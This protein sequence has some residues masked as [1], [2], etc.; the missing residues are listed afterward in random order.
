MINRGSL[1]AIGPSLDGLEVLGNRNTIT[2]NGSVRTSGHSASALHALGNSNI[3]LNTGTLNT[4]TGGAAIG[5]FAEGAGN[6]A[7]NQGTIVTGGGGAEGLSAY[8]DRNVLTNAGAIATFGPVGNGIRV[9]GNNNSILNTG[10][11]TTSG[12][13]GRGIKVDAGTGN[14][15]VNR[16]TI[17]TSGNRAYGI[18]VASRAGETTTIINE[19]SGIIR[20]RNDKF[21]KFDA[22]NE[23]VRNFG[24]LSAPGGGAAAD[25][26][27]GSDSFLIGA[28]SRITGFVDASDGTDTF[29][30]GGSANASFDAALIGAGAQY[31]NFE[32]YEKLGPSTWVVTGSNDGVMPWHV[33]QGSLLVTGV[34]GGADMNVYGGATLGGSGTV[35]SINARAGSTLTPGMNGIASLAVTGNVL[36]A[37]G[38]VYKIDLDAS[39]RS[40]RIVAEGS[41]DV[42][43]GTVQVNTL[44]GDYR[45]GSRW[46][47]LTARDGVT[48]QFLR[49]TTTL[50]FFRPVLSKDGNNIYLGLLRIQRTLP[51]NRPTPA[52]FDSVTEDELSD[53]LDQTS[54]APIVGAN[55]TILVHDDLFRAAVLCRLRC[56]EGLPT[57]STLNLVTAAYAADLPGRP[58]TTTRIPVPAPQTAQDWAIWAKAVGSW[59]STDATATS[60]ALERSTAGLVAGIDSGFGTPYRLG[61]A[62]GYFSTDLDVATLASGG[63]VESLHI[64]LYG[65]AAFGTLNLRGGVAYAH[66][67]VDMTRDIRF[68]GFS[69]TNRSSSSTDSIQAFGELGYEILLSDRV[70][71]EPFVGLAHVHVAGRGVVEEGSDLAVAG[72]VHSFDTTYSTLGARLIATMPTQAG[73]VTFKGLLGWR[74]AFGDI[75]PKAT[76]SYAG[77]GRPFLVTGASI[78]KDSLVMEAGLNW[79]MRRN[80]TVNV[81][82][83]G[84]IGRRD[85]EHTVRAGLT[86][87]F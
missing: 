2:N 67:D 6:R 19:S 74:H 69:G 21:F 61:L 46:T 65:S 57:F 71:L 59:G 68:T 23:S 3:L 79:E 32:T 48:G 15:V 36:I 56:S 14:V 51:D 75:V 27:A 24:T 66:H 33:R 16:G 18:W 43:G 39:L 76:F 55:G 22:G 20:S 7:T 4:G 35:G 12:V 9:H 54:G 64:G 5:I 1:S 86:V 81:S 29:A 41:A 38:T 78:D 47:I 80:M 30:L 11:V 8:G 26:G 45:P 17:D 82:Y 77:D 53:V 37:N 84:A 87:R 52:P 31:R 72:E 85:Q 58:V 70:V 10:N 83:S 44:P 49:A 40:D 13:E 62:V 42:R 63:T 73:T 25:L 50:A 28:S 34:M 60:H